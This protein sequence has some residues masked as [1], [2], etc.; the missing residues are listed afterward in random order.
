LDQNI[1]LQNVWTWLPAFRTVAETQH[2]PSA[3]RALHVTPSALSRSIKHLEDAIGQS[4]FT[5]EE[6]R[7]KLNRNGEILLNVVRD[8][9][10]RIDDGIEQVSASAVERVRVTGPPTWLQLVVLPVVHQM[11]QAGEPLVVDIADVRAELIVP[12]L[13]RG[14]LD[15]ALNE[16]HVAAD[17]LVAENVGE[18]VRMVCCGR[19]AI[20]RPEVPFAVYMD[21]TDPW[22]SQLPREVALWSPHLCMVI[23]ECASGRM[24]AVLPI[25]VARAFGVAVIPEPALPSSHLY[26]T[27]R[28]PLRP[29]PLDSLVARLAAQVR[30]VLDV[31]PADARADARVD[32]GAGMATGERSRLPG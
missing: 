26:L 4:L 16:I 3:A 14:D 18:V 31:A 1:R 2:L 6:R 29:T 12:A 27:R 20:G 7:I 30:T 21:G 25:A 8:A 11:R 23:E 15:L 22:P 24:Q 32:G 28:R 10:H 9:M 19:R 5:R 13:L 17:E